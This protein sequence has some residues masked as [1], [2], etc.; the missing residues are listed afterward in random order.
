MRKPLHNTSLDEEQSLLLECWYE[1]SY[2]RDNKLI[3]HD[4]LTVRLRDYL[5][6]CDLIDGNGRK[7]K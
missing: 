6:K 3:A 7:I 1:L 4:D 5:F 2:P